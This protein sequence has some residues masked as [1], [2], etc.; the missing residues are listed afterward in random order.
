[1]RTGF[2]VHP[3]SIANF[4]NTIPEIS[5]S[6]VIGFEHP[7][8]QCVP[9]AFIVLDEEKTKGKTDEE[10]RKHIMKECVSNLEQTSVPYDIVFTNDLPINLG[11]KVDQIRIARESGID[12]T[13]EPKIKKRVLY[14]KQ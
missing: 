11:G 8:E 1:M 13:K 4:L 5:Q 6:T 3:A 10:I 14:F 2:N 7:E 9:V 12:L